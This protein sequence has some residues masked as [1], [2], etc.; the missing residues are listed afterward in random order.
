M[1]STS[2]KRALTPK[3]TPVQEVNRKIEAVKRSI[4]AASDKGWDDTVSNSTVSSAGQ[5][6]L[7]NSSIEGDAAENRSGDEILLK[8]VKVNGVFNA[9]D[10][11]QVFRVMLVIDHEPK[12][13]AFALTDLLDDSVITAPCYAFRKMDYKQRFTVLY[14]QFFG[15]V[16]ATSSQQHAFK[17]RQLMNMKT[18]YYAASNTGTVADI[19]RNSLYLVLISDS[20]AVSHPS[21]YIGGRITFTK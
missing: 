5:L 3:A 7:L 14:D 18:T 15:S 16:L 11:T 13:L 1:K 20:S 12:G 6:I 2:S 10:A 19:S 21:Y 17:I 4:K 8:S 9:V